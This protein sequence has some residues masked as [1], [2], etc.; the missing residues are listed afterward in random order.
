M[1]LSTRRSI[2][3]ALALL[4]LALGIGV[5]RLVLSDSVGREVG[6]SGSPTVPSDPVPG[7]LPPRI[8]VATGPATEVSESSPEEEIAAPQLEKTIG[9]VDAPRPDP[10]DFEAR[11]RIEILVVDDLQVPVSDAVVTIR[12]LRMRGDPGSAYGYRGEEPVGCTDLDGLVRLDYWTWISKHGRTRAVDLFVT[13]P[14]FVSFRDSSF[15]VGPGIHTVELQRGATVVVSG[16]IGTPANVVAEL[17]IQVDGDSRLGSDSWRREADGRFSTDR[18]APGPH[19][20][21]LE[22]ESEA[23]GHCFSEIERFELLEGGY[24]VLPLELHPAERLEGVLDSVTPR[25][26]V[27]GNALLYLQARGPDGREPD[28]SRRFETPILADGTFSFDELPRGR[29]QIFALCRGWASRR[30]MADS[31]ADAGIRFGVGGRVR[32]SPE[33][34]REALEEFGDRAFQLQRIT[35]PPATDPFVVSMEPTATVEIVVKL[36]DGT[37]VVGASVG[38]SPNIGFIGGINTLAPW[39]S[40]RAET[41]LEGRARIEDIPRNPRVMVSAGHPDYEM[42][43]R[44]NAVEARSGETT[45]AEVIMKPRDR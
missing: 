29:G 5:L 26:I 15:P 24:E 42:R 25:P 8:E 12:G 10:P 16:W 18:L 28:I 37:P 6:V 41:D 43:W 39:R 27:D 3:I 38:A 9:F 17:T 7:A 1:E 11:D 35:I 36:E 45:T 23:H 22:H 20:I 44:R 30:T 19:L 2:T 14:G 32:V 21:M 4:V 13:H 40:W 34:E 31:A 33:R